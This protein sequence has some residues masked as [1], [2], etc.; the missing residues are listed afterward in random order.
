MPGNC[1][2][3]NNK[4]AGPICLSCLAELQD[5]VGDSARLIAIL[6]SAVLKLTRRLTKMEKNQTVEQQGI[7][8]SMN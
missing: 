2:I 1:V 5:Q 3:C 6:S 8:L 7:E 4:P